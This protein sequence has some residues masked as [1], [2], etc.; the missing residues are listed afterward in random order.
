MPRCRACGQDNPEIARFCL[1]CGSPFGASE[2]RREERK[3]ITVLFADIVGSTASAERMDPEDVWARLQPYYTR[4][5]AELERFGGTVE[6]FIGDAVVALFGAPVT[7]EDDAER[8]VRAALAVCAAMEDLNAADAWL[9]LKVRIGVNT[10]EALVVVG[11]RTSEG[12]ATAAGDVMNTAARLQSAAPVNGIVVGGETFRA[13]RDVVEYRA[14]EPVVAKGKS[15]PVSVWHAVGL[16]DRPAAPVARTPLVGRDAELEELDRAWRRVLAERRPGATGICGGPGVGKTRLVVELVERAATEADVHWGRCLSYGEGITYWPIAEILR[17]LAGV[18]SGDDRAEVAAKLDA[19]LARLP[20]DDPDELRTVAAA[21]S[22]VLG[23]PR[24]PR[25]TYASLELSRAELHWGIR[26]AFQALARRRP[27]VL[28][29]EDVHWAEP[30]L[31]ELVEQLLDGG[32]DAPLL[33]AWTARPELAETHPGFLGGSERGARLELDALPATAGEEL[34]ASLLG[35]AE[36]ARTPFAAALLA[37]A[38]GNPLFLEQTVR[39]LETDGAVDPERWRD[40]GAAASL[41]VPTS[42]QGLIASRLDRLAH[43]QK[44]MAHEAAVVGATFWAAAVAYLDAPDS[45]GEDTIA[46]LESLARQDLVQRRPQ[47]TVAGED[48]YAFRHALIRDVAYAQLPKSRRAQLHVR[49]GE[50]V[51]NLP[52]A[53]EELLEIVAW[54]LEQA[55]RLAREVARPPIEPPVIPAADA[56]AAAAQRAGQRDGLREAERYYARAL[57]VLGDADPARHLRL[58]LRRAEV[59]LGLGR[60]KEAAEE[61]EAVT[62]GGDDA[63]RCE[64]LILLADVV[65][66]QG[67]ASE[68]AARLAEAERLAQALGDTRLRAKAAFIATTVGFHYDGEAAGAVTALRDA[69]ALAAEIDEPRLLT[70]GY[71]RI[72]A[73]LMNLGRYAEAEEELERCLAAARDTA[74][75]TVRAEATAWLGG[76]KYYRGDRADGRRLG[77]QA[78]EWLE[79]TGDSYFLAQNLVWLAAYG[80]FE[81]DPARA[82]ADLRDA[83]PVALEIG[84][85]IVVQAYRYLAE[86]LLAQGRLEEARELVAFAERDVPGEDVFARTELLR[87]SGLVAAAAGDAAAA[88]AAFDEALARLEELRLPVELAETRLGLARALAL[89]GDADGARAAFAAAH[90]EC[91]QMGLLTLCERIDRAV[92]E[93]EGAG[94]AGPLVHA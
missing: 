41:S 77:L 69:V 23:I 60:L 52:R 30:T 5:R 7:H 89:V 58:R 14:G 9:D 64:A 48:E 90:D 29:L 59:L 6:K 8:A 15:E 73:L 78:R 31:L 19:L 81:D 49:F 51:E 57:D 20:T 17:S 61:L 4:V 39:M 76:I 65:Q 56:L 94:P 13:T 79:R 85:W 50:W 80:L 92:A 72:A 10:G 24:T 82:E 46:A 12:E 1:A 35:D 34:L 86:A 87:A 91:D 75:L 55:C 44:R 16:R 62:S 63:V 84:G 67:L 54:H 27:L 45:G 47:S 22:N 53:A 32:D 70:E 37:N 74:S 43:G 3:V 38:A 68:A 36:L 71:L 2:A 42:V 93:L 33:V 40:A 11:A 66:R 21:V 28:V 18:V 25:G 83:L 88:G 26:R